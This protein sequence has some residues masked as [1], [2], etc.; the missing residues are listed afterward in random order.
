M[1]ITSIRANVCSSL[2]C[3][4]FNKRTFSVQDVKREIKMRSQILLMVL[5]ALE[6]RSFFEDLP[7][8]LLSQN[9]HFTEFVNIKL[10]LLQRNIERN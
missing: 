8:L 2:Q 9:E 7:E 1:Y 3:L 10:Q 4:A 5:I 6:V